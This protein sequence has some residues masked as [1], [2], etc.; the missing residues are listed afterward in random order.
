MTHLYITNNPIRVCTEAGEIIKE[1][2]KGTD[3]TTISKYLVNV[4]DVFHYEDGP[5][6]LALGTAFDKLMEITGRKTR[7]VRGELMPVKEITADYIFPFG[8]NSGKKASEVPGHYLA[9][10]Q[11]TIAPHRW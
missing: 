1:F 4:G 5:F 2:P 10:W 7:S 8:G 11:K 3:Y 9:W 6:G